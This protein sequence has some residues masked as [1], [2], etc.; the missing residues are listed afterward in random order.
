MKKE[1][2]Q[3]MKDINEFVLYCKGWYTMTNDKIT[4]IY[5]LLVKTP[6]FAYLVKSDMIP[7]IVYK[8]SNWNDKLPN[9]VKLTISDFWRKYNHERDILHVNG[10]P[11]KD[12]DELSLDVIIHHIRY[13]DP[14]YIELGKPIYKKGKAR[15]WFWH[16]GMTYKQLNKYADERF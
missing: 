16:E 11:D 2:K 7:L 10:K 13:V 6:Q 14:K 15:A 8:W 4:D 1:D 5:A 3:I 9:D 12:F